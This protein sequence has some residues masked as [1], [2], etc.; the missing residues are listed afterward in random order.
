MGS[1]IINFW[2]IDNGISL[3][4]CS[5]CSNFFPLYA[6]LL[7]DVK[8]ELVSVMGRSATDALLHLISSLWLVSSW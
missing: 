3:P 5:L 1:I 4:S 8:A 2:V 7:T 6:T